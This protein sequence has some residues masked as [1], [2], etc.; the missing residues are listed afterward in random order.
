MV[1]CSPVACHGSFA[2][3]TSS[4]RTG[5]MTSINP[6]RTREARLGGLRFWVSMT[7]ASSRARSSASGTAPWALK[8]T[9]SAS[10]VLYIAAQLTVAGTSAAVWR[11]RSAI[12]RCTIKINWSVVVNRQYRR[13]QATS[14]VR[15]GS[16]ILAPA[17]GGRETSRRA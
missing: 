17:D 14:T 1:G 2:I 3:A 7:K 4:E 6:S 5:R 10:S 11:H 13:K 15:A 8:A 9:S 12:R 16:L